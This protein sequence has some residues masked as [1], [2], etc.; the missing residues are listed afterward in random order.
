VIR[1]LDGEAV[2]SLLDPRLALEAMTDLFAM[3]VDAQ[4]YGRI[5]LHHDR[6]WIRVLPGYLEQ[7]EVFG[8][9]V[10]SRTSE[11]GMRYAVHVHDLDSGAL[12]GMVDGLSVTNARTG[13]VSA[14]ATD[15]LAVADVEVAALIGTG[16]VGRGQLVALDLVRSAGVTRVFSPTQARRE[17]LVDQMQGKVACD[18]VAAE[19]L[20]SAIDGAQMVTLAT[21]ATAPVLMAGH[22]APGM[23][24]NSVGPASRDRHEIDADAFPVFDQVVCDS[25]VLVLNEAGDAI[26]AT[27]HGTLTAEGAVDLA[28]MLSTGGG[29][30]SADEITLFKSVGT[31]L[32]DL[33]VALRLLEKADRADIGLV[34]DDFVTLKPFGVGR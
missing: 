33:I 11:V 31:G 2:G 23:H 22:L 1:V 7:L 12:R 4:V 19:S 20:E 29:R 24:V 21:N 27:R 6:G 13:A 8:Y 30:R 5:D 32:Q 26:E 16:P 28:V 17:A 25:V 14:L 10:L 3:P 34:I 15:L 18:L 9:K